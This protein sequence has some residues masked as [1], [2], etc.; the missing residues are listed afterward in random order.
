MQVRSP[1]S[2]R[3]WQ[4]VLEPL[5]GYLVL[6]WKLFEGRR[7]H[8]E[9]WNFGPGEDGNSSVGDVLARVKAE[10][11]AL[12]WQLAEKPQLHEAQLLQLD[13]AKA[14]R[15]LQWRPVWDLSEAVSTTVAWYRAYLERGSV[16]SAAQIEEY[17]AAARRAGLA[18][19]G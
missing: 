19:A 4:H 10:W 7:E 9:A 2:T 1:A 11:P 6:G 8:C 3:P 5:S 12:D 13:S 14:R 18:W 16:T 15:R 17:V